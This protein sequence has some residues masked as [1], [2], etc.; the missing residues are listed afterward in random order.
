MPH[1]GTCPARWD[2]G[3]TGEF[4]LPSLGHSLGMW[5]CAAPDPMSAVSVCTCRGDRQ[6]KDEQFTFFFAQNKVKRIIT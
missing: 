5:V 6:K 4:A 2:V 1:S 3:V